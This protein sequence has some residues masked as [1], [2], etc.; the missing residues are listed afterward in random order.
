MAVE[1][2]A[3][4]RGKLALE[5]F[6]EIR[7]PTE[8]VVSPDGK[9]LAFSVSAS[10]AEKGKRPESTIWTG[11]PDGDYAQATR[12]S[13]VDALPRWSSRGVLAF[14]SDR[15]HPGRMSLQLL[16]P[17]PGEARPQGQ[18][19][20][21]VEDMQWSPDGKTLLVLAADPGSDRAGIQAATKIQEQGAEE[22]DPKVTRPFQA[23]R[24]LY[25]V[26]AESGE[27]RVVS[28]ERVHVFEFDWDGERVVAVCSDEPSESAWYNAYL[29]ALDLEA[30]TAETLYEP[31][32]QIE[33]PCLSGDGSSVCFVE[34][35]CSDRGVLAGD[36]KALDLSSR[37]VREIETECDIASLQ[38]AG[39][40]EFW[41]GAWRGM[42][43][44]CGR[45]SLDGDADEVWSGEATVGARFQPRVSVG[46]GLV[47]AVLDAP[48]AP[49]DVAVLEDG[50]WRR[51]TQLNP[52]APDP[53]AAGSWERWT[54]TAADGL[55]L[56]GL[57][58]RPR[59]GHEPFPLVVGVH[60]GPTGC[61]AHSW[62][63]YGPVGA[64]LAQE[65]YAV[66]LPNPRGSAGRGQEFARAN[67]GDMG[68]GDLQ[69]ILA[70]VDSLVEAG[71]ADTERVGVTGGSYGGFMSAWAVT[72]TDRFACSIPLASVTDWRSFH[73][74]TNIGQF[75]TLFL[76]ADPYEVGGEYDAR[77]PVVQA[78]NCK[79]PTL[80]IHGQEDLCVP[81]SQA[82]E[83][84]QALVEA[85]CE[86]ELVLYPREGHGMLERDHVL[87]L[88]TR[89]R[90]WFA[91]Y[92][93]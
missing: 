75:D 39:E 24:R 1:E 21:S 92:L 28:P 88:W 9:R 50:D 18:I 71:I 14:A 12:G 70:G 49:A 83:M 15:G 11:D 56:E 81:V 31:K 19:D 78:K 54:W 26:D 57:L 44:V 40:R 48:G 73:H 77:S 4:A 23:W 6:L 27:T 36:V 89:I 74:T 51:V 79:T 58:L 93:G 62:L 84:Y 38:R 29:A 5:Q 47:A 25:L 66:F 45:I 16:G 65:G 41:F 60:G 82:Q 17:G 53:D 90:D 33:A 13:G 72:Q 37:G 76:D 67:L 59:E 87:N 8:V 68:G 20:G 32:W 34:G 30:R 43:T 86:T 35:F 42:T 80:L 64:L 91:R 3:P 61:Y 52:D 69:D 46:G 7:R 10:C 63:P 2:R 22:E 85:G 55:E